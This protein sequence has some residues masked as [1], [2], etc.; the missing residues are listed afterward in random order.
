MIVSFSKDLWSWPWR[1]DLDIW[2]WPTPCLKKKLQNCFCQ[3]FVKFPPI[4]VT[5]GRKMAKWL[6]LCKVH[7]FSTSP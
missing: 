4:L 3:N 6:K 1:C 2:T 5:F 7:S